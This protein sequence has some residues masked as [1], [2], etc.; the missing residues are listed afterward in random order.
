MPEFDPIAVSATAPVQKGDIVRPRSARPDDPCHLVQMILECDCPHYGPHPLHLHFVC[1]A[2]EAG[3]WK[4][5]N[6]GQTYHG[7]YR[8]EGDRLLGR[9]WPAGSGQYKRNGG[10]RDELFL[11]WREPV[12]EPI[13]VASAAKARPCDPNTT[14]T[15]EGW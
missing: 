8:Y 11:V 10:E 13:Q 4:R 5:L 2:V 3:T 14:L 7:G 12:P 15:L 9:T 1:T 6:I